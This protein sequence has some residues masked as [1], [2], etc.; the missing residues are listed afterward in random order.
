MDWRVLFILIFVKMM[1]SDLDHTIFVYLS[2]ME[3]IEERQLGE[4][5]GES[6]IRRVH[7]V[8]PSESSKRKTQELRRKDDQP[9]KA[10]RIPRLTVIEEGWLTDGN[11]DIKSGSG[12]KRDSGHHGNDSVLFNCPRTG[13]ERPFLTKQCES[14]SRQDSGKDKT[15]RMGDELNDKG[16]DVDTRLAS[17]KP[18]VETWIR[19]VSEENGHVW[20]NYAPVPTAA[21]IVPMI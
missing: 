20:K 11:N 15:Q 18:D 3:G 16:R 9:A 21:K 14:S 17:A 2:S 7:K 4:V 6:H 10:L 5:Q 19:I 12:G 1:F 13:I 8:L